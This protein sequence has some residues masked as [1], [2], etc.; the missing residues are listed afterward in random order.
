MS[1]INRHVRLSGLGLTW[2]SQNLPVKK[3]SNNYS[4]ADCMCTQH[5][6]SWHAETLPGAFTLLKLC[7]TRAVASCTYSQHTVLWRAENLRLLSLCHKSVTQMLLQSAPAPS[8]LFCSVQNI[9]Q[10]LSLCLTSQPFC[11]KSPRPHCNTRHHFVACRQL[12]SCI[13]TASQSS[14]AT[15]DP[16]SATLLASVAIAQQQQQ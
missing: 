6:M 11:F 15:S 12:T 1:C 5:T 3:S 4:A 9:C 10:L 14:Y 13:H 16:I 7:N 8:T 2:A